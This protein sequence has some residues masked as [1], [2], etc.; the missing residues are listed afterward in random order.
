MT[1][2]GKFDTILCTMRVRPTRLTVRH[3]V[4]VTV[5]L[6]L[7]WAPP[8]SAAQDGPARDGAAG[9]RATGDRTADEVAGRGAPAP[10]VAPEGRWLDRGRWLGLACEGDHLRLRDL[11]SA[12]GIDARPSADA[13]AVLGPGGEQLLAAHGVRVLRT[14]SRAASVA[15]VRSLDAAEDGVA[16]AARLTPLLDEAGPLRAVYPDLALAVVPTD[17]AVPPNDPLYGGQWY[18]SRIG[19]E[20]AWRTSTGSAAVTITIVDNG[21]DLSHPDLAPSFLPGRDVLA[22]DDDPSFVPGVSGNEHGT[23]C[24]GVAGAVGHNGVGIA[25]AC[26]AC[27]LRCVRMLGA[28]G[29]LIPLSVNVAA[30]DTAI[31]RGDAVISNSWGFAEAIP[32]PSPLA[33]VVQAAFDEGRGG[34]GALVVFAAGN[35]DRLLGDDELTAVRGVLN[36]GAI[37]NRDEATSFTNRGRSV[38]LCAPTGTVTTDIVG[39]DGNDPGDY[40]SL[41][42]GTSSAA[43]VVAGVAGLLFAAF[44]DATASEVHDALIATARPAPYATP[45]PD[46]HD[47]VYGFGIVDPAAALAALAGARPPEDAGAGDDAGTD[48]G[49]GERPPA[50]DGCGC[51]AA[52]TGHAAAGGRA[53]RGGRADG[54]ALAARGALVAVGAIALALGRA[55]ARRRIARDRGVTRR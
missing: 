54:G 25:G 55:R 31:E 51:R 43:P 17:V 5:A 3:L 41:F 21:C 20:R 7:A 48:G 23:A 10:C 4:A 2:R 46:G 50:G 38:D 52:G 33:R 22:G 53:D 13:L 30:F 44:P 1:A 18:L 9:G 12:R 14:L 27:T 34:K 37:R 47:E 26:P 45:G 15:L 24:A 42:G 49:E 35:D 32:V 40:S 39:P 6:A 19:I 16:L 36:V 29:E 28:R 8:R 11:Q